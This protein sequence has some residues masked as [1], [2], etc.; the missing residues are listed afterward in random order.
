MLGT[1]VSIYHR[2][3]S[4]YHEEICFAYRRASNQGLTDCRLKSAQETITPTTQ[5]E[6]YI[7]TYEEKSEEPLRPSTKPKR[8]SKN[9]ALAFGVI[10]LELILQ[11]SN[12]KTSR[13]IEIKL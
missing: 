13:C 8:S 9:L 10:K 3:K 7:E 1:T 12:S 5:L 4:T 6:I 11:G 2:N